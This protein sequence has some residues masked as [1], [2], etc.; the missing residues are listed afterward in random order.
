MRSNPTVCDRRQFDE[1]IRRF[2]A[3]NAE[4]PNREVSEGVTYPKAL[5]Y[6]KRMTAWL[7]RLEPSASEPLRL[8]VR[9][10]HI[11]RWTIPRNRYAEGRQGYKPWRTTRATFHADVAGKI[12]AQ[13]GYDGDSIR[14]VQALL[15]KERLKADPETQSLEDVVCLVFL[16]SY[17]ATFAEQHSEKKLIGII[18]KTWK[19]MSPRGHQAALALNLPPHLKGII[20]KALAST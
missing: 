17:A 10:Q 8:A 16:D 4:D 20:D 12:L 5:L 3:A 18:R 14:R 15:R 2:D 19:K 7:D 1:A 11:C 9:C 6:A 13:V